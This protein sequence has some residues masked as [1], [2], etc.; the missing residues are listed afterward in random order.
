MLVVLS[1][2]GV[3]MGIT[4]GAFR[5][6]VPARDLA[7]NAVLGAL[8]QARLF[9]IS[10]NAPASVRMV[11]DVHP[12]VITLGKQTVGSWHLE[13]EETDG[14]P[15][16]LAAT[17]HSE[18]P[19]GVYGKALR[20]S[21]GAFSWL[22]CGLSPSFD[23]ERGFACEFFLRCERPRNQVLLSKGKGV[24]LRSDAD[25]GLSLQIR[26]V[27]RNEEGELAD[28]FH[29]LAS[30]RPALAAGRWC[31][32]A[33]S[34]DGQ[35]LRLVADDRVVAETLLPAPAEFRPDRDAPLRIGATE[36][37]SG[38]AIDELKWAVY[39][40][41]T[42]ELRDMTLGQGATLVRFGPDGALDPQFHA[43]PVEICLETQ[44]AAEGERGRQT[45]IRVGLLGDLH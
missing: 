18:E 45:W 21:D 41:T 2:V 28:V 24:V 15:G 33:A 10:E 30:A 22:D 3:L 5:R 44:P 16:P 6:S 42:Q 7:R 27:G 8:R 43:A 19:A 23:S 26:V 17:G 25:G 36:Q 37:P 4:V 38:F 29:S 13:G 39:V 1:I 20:L 9:A 31:Q 34:F 11:A 35:G 14:F 40:G 12:L 32:I